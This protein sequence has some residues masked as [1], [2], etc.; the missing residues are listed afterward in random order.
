MWGTG[1]EKNREEV[2]VGRINLSLQTCLFFSPWP[3]I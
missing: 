1:K 3:S 2:V